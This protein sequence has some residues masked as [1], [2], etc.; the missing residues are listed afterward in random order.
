M[1]D[2][3]R[4]QI[5]GRDIPASAAVF[6]P[7]E[8]VSS[9]DYDALLAELEGERENAKEWLTEHYA[10]QA[11]RD[12]LRAELEAIRGQQSD[13]VSVPR[14]LLD[15]GHLIRTQDNRC[16][17]AP[18]FAVMK[19]RPIVA[20]PDHDYDYIEWVNV[21]KDYAVAS[22]FRARR[23]E[24]LYEGCREIPE[25]W[26]RFAMKEIDVFVTACFTEQG[27]KDFLARDGHNHRK[28]F[29]YAFGSYRNAEFRAVRDWLAARPSTKNAEEDQP[30][31]K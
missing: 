18:L 5:G 4:Y 1:S 12:Q 16:T 22:E 11:E 2:V 15:V 8:V 31:D 10:L 19:K 25:G 17:D 23:L 30:C 21:D 13:A 14:E 26:E 6:L 9:A 27:C 28:P 3:K 7:S 24:A 29:I 20:S